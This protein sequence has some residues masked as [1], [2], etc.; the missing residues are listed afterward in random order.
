MI[1]NE[2]YNR[3]TLKHYNIQS[4][5]V[6]YFVATMHYQIPLYAPRLSFV[7]LIVIVFNVVAFVYVS[8]DGNRNVYFIK[9]SSAEVT[10]AGDDVP[11]HA[12]CI[13]IEKLDPDTVPRNRSIFFIE[14]NRRDV[15]ELTPRQACSVE[16]AAR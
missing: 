15:V 12:A 14:T 9:Q 2:N 8:Y 1:I 6:V 16:S 11:G 3:F 7:V 10:V 5:P 4:E 13:R